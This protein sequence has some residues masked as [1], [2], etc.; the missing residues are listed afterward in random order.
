MGTAPISNGGILHS[1]L[2]ITLLLICGLDIIDL[3]LSNMLG[4]LCLGEVSPMVNSDLIIWV[5]NWLGRLLA[6]GS[7]LGLASES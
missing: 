2:P 1:H 4:N 6:G 5:R 7:P 3:L